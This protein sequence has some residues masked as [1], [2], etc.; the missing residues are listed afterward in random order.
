MNLLSHEVWND[1]GWK[2]LN[3]PIAFPSFNFTM[4]NM[5]Q[6]FIHRKASDGKATDNFKDMNSRAYP[7]FKAGHIQY[8]HHKVLEEL[9]LMKCTCYPEMKKAIIYNIRAA[10][11]KSCDVVFATCGCPAGLGPTCSCKHYGAFCYFI[12]EFCRNRSAN[13]LYTSSTSSLQQWN[14]PRKRS[15]SPHPIESIKFIKAEYGKDLKRVASNSYDP[16]PASLRATTSDDIQQLTCELSQLKQP[17]AML[18]VLPI[19]ISKAMDGTVP[20]LPPSPILSVSQ[21]QSS[22]NKEAQPIS[23]AS[24]Y[25]HAMQLLQKLSYSQEDCK[26]VELA[27]RN[28]SQCVRRQYRI[29]ASNFGTICKG[30]ITTS[31]LKWLLCSSNSSIQTSSAIVWGKLHEPSAFEQYQA[32]LPS[33]MVLR[34]A[35][36]YISDTGFL[37]ASPDGIVSSVG[38]IDYGIIEIK[39]PYTCRNMSVVEACSKIKPFYCE[40]EN[41]Q[42][43]LKRNHQYYYQVQGTMGIVGVEWCDFVIWTTKGMTIERIQFDKIFWTTCLTYLKSVYLEYVLPEIIYPRI[44]NNLD[45]V[46]YNFQINTHY[47]SEP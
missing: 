1:D 27:T 35:G 5:I 41:G 36:I 29:T 44:S 39:C 25:N 2:L 19:A 37:A 28:Q 38:E 30:A 26:V 34:K 14:Q 16:R 18:H 31:K 23:L 10:F 40:L 4:A 9:L 46:H 22:L 13:A 3:E 17:V 12:E 47:D 24:L 32:Q 8:V 20:S 45:I 21:I 7:L 15:S 6:Y 11:D 43:K 33:S 42:V